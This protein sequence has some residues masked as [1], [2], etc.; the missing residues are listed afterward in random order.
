MTDENGDSKE[1]PD[2]VI[3]WVNVASFALHKLFSE[4]QAQGTNIPLDGIPSNA[5]AGTVSFLISFLLQF[6]LFLFSSLPEVTNLMKALSF[7]I[8]TI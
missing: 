1:N 7:E 3:P 6:Y 8:V 4:W 5:T 2:E